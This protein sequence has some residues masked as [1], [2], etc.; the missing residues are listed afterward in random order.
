[1]KA[2]EVRDAS[3][4]VEDEELALFALNG[5]DSSYDTFVIVITTTS[6]DLSFSEFKGL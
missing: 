5:L 3:I 1:M 4:I 6:G 2:D